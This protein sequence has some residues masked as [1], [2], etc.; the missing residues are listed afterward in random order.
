[1]REEGLRF[2]HIKYYPSFSHLGYWS[3]LYLH[4]HIP[5]TWTVRTNIYLLHSA[6]AAISPA[7][8]LIYNNYCSFSRNSVIFGPPVQGEN[9]D[10]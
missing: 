4:L 9:L 6:A 5:H 1:M 10:P 2:T 8:F 7:A 3:P